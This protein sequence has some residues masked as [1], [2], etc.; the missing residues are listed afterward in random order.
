MKI[1]DLYFDKSYYLINSDGKKSLVKVIAVETTK[2]DK[3]YY[4][5]QDTLGAMKP[6][7]ISAEEANYLNFINVDDES[8]VKLPLQP[9]L[10]EVGKTY[11]F[12]K[13]LCNYS[14]KFI[15]D[16]S[17]LKQGIVTKELIRWRD[18]LDGEKFIAT[19][20]LIVE[21]NGYSVQPQWCIEV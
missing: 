12:K 16:T 10:F 7:R 13:S 8:E 1:E 21:V 9:H 19:D 6:A 5:V 14:V 3:V 2:D 17:K 18:E 20:R 4:Y 11:R 15:A